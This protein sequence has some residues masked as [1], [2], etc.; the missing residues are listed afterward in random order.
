MFLSKFGKS[1]S[2]PEEFQE[3][4]EIFIK[5]HNISLHQNGPS[6]MKLNH[7]AD[8][9]DDEYLSILGLHHVEQEDGQPE[10]K[11]VD[12]SNM[13]QIDPIDWRDQ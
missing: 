4:R 13:P 12:R 6:L 3:R 8:W 11:Y 5:N 2:D 10:V 7:M 9:S 1:Y